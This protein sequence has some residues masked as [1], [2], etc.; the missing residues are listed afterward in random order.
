MSAVHVV[1]AGSD[2]SAADA[3]RC[4]LLSDPARVQALA[5]SGLTA[6]ADEQMQA[7][8]ERVF[9]GMVGLQSRGRR[10]APPR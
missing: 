8:A 1:T 6:V 4:A 2:Q 5:E 7:L 10:P 3:V 9:P